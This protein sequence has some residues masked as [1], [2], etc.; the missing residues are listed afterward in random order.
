MLKKVNKLFDILKTNNK[1]DIIMKI[2]V[3]ITKQSSTNTVP[4]KIISYLKNYEKDVF[5]IPIDIFSK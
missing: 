2:I 1:E 3:T 4:E 5:V